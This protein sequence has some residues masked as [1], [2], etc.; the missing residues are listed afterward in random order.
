MRP[1]AAAEAVKKMCWFS[2]ERGVGRFDVVKLLGHRFLQRGG[3][4]CNNAVRCA[5]AG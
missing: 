3:D 5:Q 1:A 2:N 4:G